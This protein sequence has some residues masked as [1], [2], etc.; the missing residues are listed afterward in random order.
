M[1]MFIFIIFYYYYYV[2]IIIILGYK[3][4][5]VHFYFILIPFSIILI[6]IFL[7]SRFFSINKIVI[8]LWRKIKYFQI[9]SLLLEKNLY[10]LLSL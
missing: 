2:N 5:Y 9:I 3:Y 6:N 10:D 8:S 7:S 1:Y 4:Y